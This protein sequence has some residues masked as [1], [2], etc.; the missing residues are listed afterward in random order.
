[1]PVAWRGPRVVKTWKAVRAETDHR[2]VLAALL[3]MHICCVQ[4]DIVHQQDVVRCC[5]GIKPSQNGIFAGILVEHR[6][7]WIAS[8]NG[9]IPGTHRAAFRPTERRPLSSPGR[10]NGVLRGRRAV[11]RTRIW[12]RRFHRAACA[13][14][15]AWIAH[16]WTERYMA[17]SWPD[18]CST[19]IA[20]CAPKSED[21]SRFDGSCNE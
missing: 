13:M 5:C 12:G 11:L 16:D 9:I 14:S 17:A 21:Q 6:S 1:M 3:W 18:I 8:A 15:T 7:V 4:L 20:G 10:E 2:V 19:R